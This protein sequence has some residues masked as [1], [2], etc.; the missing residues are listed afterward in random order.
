MWVN[1]NFIYNSP[2]QQQSNKDGY[3]EF[4]LLRNLTYQVAHDGFVDPLEAKTPNMPSVVVGNLLFPVHQNLSLSATTLSMP[5]SGGNNTSITYT[6]TF[7][8]HNT[9]KLNNDWSGVEVEYSVADIVSISYDD[10]SLIIAP[11]AQGVTTVTFVR[12]L[13]EDYIFVN[14]P[15]FTSDSL[16]ITVT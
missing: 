14:P 3:F 8:D 7:S 9:G 12:K 5:F 15:A 4:D 1:T 11:V 16:V 2:V 13:V 6:A 10:T